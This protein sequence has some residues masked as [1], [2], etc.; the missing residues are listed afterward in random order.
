MIQLNILE[1]KDFTRKL[2]LEDTFDNFLITE[3]EFKTMY[4]VSLR[5]SLL[6]PEEGKEEFI[7]WKEVRPL[8]FQII[9]GNRI[10]ESFRVILRLSDVNRQ[11]TLASIG[12]PEA[13]VS[14][15]YMNIR[16]EGSKLAVVT[17]CS[18]SAFSMDKT[19]EKEWDEITRRFFR[20][21]QIPFEEA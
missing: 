8:A 10:P 3:A 19:P 21:H 1:N 7:T 2:F 17:G 11:K 6:H 18:F 5:G 9:K 20:H 16:F 14:G 4:T 13:P 12:L 15:F